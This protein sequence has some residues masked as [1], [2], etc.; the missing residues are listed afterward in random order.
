[1]NMI[2]ISANRKLR[3]RS[4]NLGK[5]RLNSIAKSNRFSLAQLESRL[6]LRIRSNSPRAPQ[7]KTTVKF[8]LHF[9]FSSRSHTPLL[10]QR[11][12]LPATSHCFRRC[13]EMADAH[14]R[15]PWYDA[16]ATRASADQVLGAAPAG[17]FI[18]RPSTKVG[19]LALSAK[20]PT[21][22]RI[23]MFDTFILTHFLLQGVVIHAVMR[24][25]EKGWQINLGN[26]VSSTFPTVLQL[27]QSLQ[28][29][30]LFEDGAGG[31]GGASTA[32]GGFVGARRPVVGCD[33][34]SSSAASSAVSS[35]SSSSSSSSN[36]G[37]AG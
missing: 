17:R 20:D 30:L 21:V 7:T 14:T 13:A 19:C 35:S 4:G 11:R 24:Q 9:S 12:I 22:I 32:S 26:S 25:K 2:Q 29:D 23:P 8:V 27:L 3:M 28:P 5:S 1:M 31:G 18:V 6:R 37:G 36:G 33:S 34:S 15:F 16:N 10:D